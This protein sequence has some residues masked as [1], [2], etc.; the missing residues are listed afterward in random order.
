MKPVSIAIVGA[1]AVG[2]TSA[3]ALLLRNLAARIMLVDINKERCDGHVRDLSDALAFS[4]VS[5]VEQVEFDEART[6]DI[7]VIAAGKRQEPGETRMDLLQANYRMLCDV[8]KKLQPIN[9]HACV[10]MVTNPLDPLTRIAQDHLDLPKNQVFGSGTLLDSQRLKKMV[11]RDLGVAPQSVDALVLGEHGDTQLVP[12]SRAQLI[13]ASLNDRKKL[14]EKDTQE[15]ALRAKNEVYEIIKCKGATYFGIATCVAHIC[16][17]IIF[18]AKELMPVSCFVP[19]LGTCLSV[20]AI[21]GTGGVQEI[22]MP[23][24]TKEEQ[25]ALETSAQAVKKAYA[26][27][28]CVE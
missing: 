4:T 16:Q 23:T 21:V 7:I 5:V 22:V 10:L 8:L 2:T 20:P 15:L 25:A 26:S 17:C 24:L 19:E 1:G 9:Q 13:G 27:V 12:W 18:D 6:A 28:T 3:Y 14:S 11:S